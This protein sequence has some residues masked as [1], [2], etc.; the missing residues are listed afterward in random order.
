LLSL[1]LFLLFFSFL[2]FLLLMKNSILF[3]MMV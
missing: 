3:K 2:F 1:E